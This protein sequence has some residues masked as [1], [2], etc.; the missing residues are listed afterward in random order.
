VRLAARTLRVTEVDV[1]RKRS[2]RTVCRWGER[3]PKVTTH[4]AASDLVV[5]AEL[6]LEGRAQRL[7]I[8]VAHM[9]NP[10][11]M[12]MTFVPV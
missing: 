11:T 2:A 3:D 12:S 9:I 8:R 5:Y 7:E 4:A 6:S 10:M 1:H